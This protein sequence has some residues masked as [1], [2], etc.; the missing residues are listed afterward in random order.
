MAQFRYADPR[1]RNLYAIGGVAAFV[2]LASLLAM[3]VVMVAL[4]PKPA[5]VEELFILQQTSRLESILRGD[6]LLLF[7]I[8]PY[9]FTFSALYIAL[10]G[11][12]PVGAGLATLMTFVAVAGFF[13]T[14]SSF[15]LLYLGDK[16]GQAG[17]EA[18]RTQLL[19]AGEAVIASDSWNSSAGY[20]GGILLQGAG[21]II[22]IIMLR[23]KDF[24]KLTAW[25]GLLGNGFDLAQ[26]ILY[27][28]TP[29]F[30][31]FLRSFMGVFYLVW[32]PMLGWDLLR[33]ERR[34]S[35]E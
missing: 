16:Y 8:G 22:S 31:M 34:R 35:A 19:T 32:F 33:L 1:W 27:P 14:E 12:S 25:A 17:S 21:V 2:Q 13:A 9:L 3:L 5:S 11:V 29:S 30:S 15:S 18:Q 7:L 24:N 6:F 20:A 4:G 26:H 23:S 28:F 10:R